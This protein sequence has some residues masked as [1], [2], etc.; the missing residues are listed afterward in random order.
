MKNFKNTFSAVVALAILTTSAGY[1]Q[2]NKQAD[3]PAAKSQKEVEK[4]APSEPN[5]MLYTDSSRGRPF[6][7]DPDVV[8]FKGK[9]YMYY[10]MCAFG[11]NRPG[12]GLAMGIAESNDLTHWFK[13]GE[14]LPEQDC[15]KNGLVAGAAI[16]IGGKVHLFYSTYGN[17]KNDAICHAFS[18]DGIHFARNPTNPIFRP[19]GDWNCGRAIDSDIIEYK[20]KWFLYCAT[21]DPNYKIQM[22]TGATAPHDCDFSRNCWTQ[23]GNGPLLKPELTWEQTCIEAPTCC[24]HDGRLYMFYAGAYNNRPQ[25]IGCAV[26]DDGIAWKRLSDEPLLPNGKPGEWNSSES[27]HPGVFTDN[28]GQMYLFFQGNNNMGKSWYLSKM[29]IG[30]QRDRPYLFNP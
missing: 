26:S 5:M 14:I 28:D 2:A 29:K 15:E 1:S 27:G 3:V 11:D 24:I 4:T 19:T 17:R 13:A 9:Y 30:W 21:R 7:K 25:Q 20:D 22:L 16:V 8:N 23:I 18:D 10:T 6:A 12:D